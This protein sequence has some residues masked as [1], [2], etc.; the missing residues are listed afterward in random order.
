[1][2]NK[3]FRN[4]LGPLCSTLL[5][6]NLTHTKSSVTQLMLCCPVTTSEES[7]QL[8]EESGQCVVT[9]TCRSAQFGFS[10]SPDR[11]CPHVAILEDNTQENDG[12]CLSV[13]N[14]LNHIYLRVNTNAC[15]A[16]NFDSILKSS[17]TT[18]RVLFVSAY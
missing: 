8:E 1:M 13:F 7:F 5:F 16:A 11:E 3:L 2:E 12:E 6:M 14:L 4:I 18:S 15:Y 9:G 10:G 17:E